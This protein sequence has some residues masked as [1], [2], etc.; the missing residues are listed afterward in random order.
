MAYLGL[1]LGTTG[2]KAVLFDAEGVSIAS[3]YREYSVVS[4]APGH[5]EL[6]PLR[7]WQHVRA[8]ITECL[9]GSGEAEVEALSVSSLGEALVPMGK[10]RRPLGNS[11]LNYDS[12]GGEYVDA[13]RA[14]ISDEELYRVNGNAAGP[15]YSATRLLWY[16]KQNNEI[17]EKTDK[18]LLWGGYILYMLGGDA[19]T[20]YSLANRTLLLDIEK[21]CWNSSLIR[22]LGLDEDKLPELAEPG[23]V[24]GRM[25]AGLADELGFR[26][27]PLLVVGT[28]DQCANAIGSGA[29]DR[30]KAMYGMGTF[31]CIVSPFTERSGAAEMLARGLNT[32]HHAVP[33]RWVTF[34]YN[35]GGILLKWFRDTF[36]ADAAASG[37]S[38]LFGRL[39]D[40]MPEGPSPVSV[41]P[42]LMTT[43]TPAF[44][45]KTSGIISGLTVDTRRGD[46]C[47]GVLEGIAF[48][49]KQN[50][51]NLPREMAIDRFTVVGGGSKSDRWMQLTADILQRPCERTLEAEAGSLGAAAIA[52]C[53][54][55]RYKDISEA[56]SG[57]VRA[58]RVFDPTAAPD[59]YL[60]NYERYCRIYPLFGGFL[61]EYKK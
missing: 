47:K 23:T 16:L 30:G 41:L 3:A 42:H 40:E 4:D 25:P 18:F 22:A 7:I 39:L 53:G 12:R 1:D 38:G 50:L 14:V 21:G 49:L 60:E 27:P 37:E 51:D 32:E 29:L 35:Q 19:V 6:D 54:A 56:V 26:R 24:C 58:G 55:G 33:G 28:H 13:V 17:Y 57:M 10:D 59:F 43:G 2:C 46:I 8:I 45:E 34:I 9:A 31:H 5:A 48:Y 36:A 20:D 11:L 52:A 61:S 15:N 44:I